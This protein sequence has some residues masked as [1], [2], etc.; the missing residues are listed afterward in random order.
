MTLGMPESMVLEQLGTD[1]ILRKFP[2]GVKPESRANPPDSAWS[3]QRK[4]DSGF[5]MVGSVTFD[6]H[7]LTTAIRNWDVQ[8]YA[9]KSLFYAVSE[10]LKSLERDGLTACRIATYGTSRM[11]DSPTGTGSGS[12]NT[13]EI[14]ID[15]EIKQVKI[16]LNVSDAPG[17]TPTNIQVSEWLQS[18]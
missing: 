4:T 5:V 16:T 17:M 8:A 18:K 3:I 15:C 1:F 11:I 2:S 7:K 6:D 10:A 9:S 14:L 12:L 13:Q